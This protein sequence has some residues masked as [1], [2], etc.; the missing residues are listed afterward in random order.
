MVDAIFVPQ[1]AEERVVRRALARCGSP[2]VVYITGLGCTAAAAAAERALEAAPAPRRG[3]ISGLCG[4]RTPS[5]APGDLLLYAKME[6]SGREVATDPELTAELQRAIPRALSGVRAVEVEEIVVRASD[7]RVLALAT[8]AQAVDMESLTLAERFTRAGSAVAVL[9]AVSDGACD[10]IPDFNRA[11]DGAGA[12]DS[13]TL[14]WVMARNP[15]QAVRTMKH[16]TRALRA[17]E[18]AVKALSCP[19]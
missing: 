16:A 2:A 12:M 3:L 10:D 14:A 9:R 4:G 15:I 6:S 11:L 8:G 1:G 5:V 17:L 19:P 7:K 13:R 18:R